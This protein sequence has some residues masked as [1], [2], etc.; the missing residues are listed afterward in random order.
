M[1]NFDTG[2][3]IFCGLGHGSI[4]RMRKTLLVGHRSHLPFCILTVKQELSVDHKQRYHCLTTLFDDSSNYS[5]YHKA[6]SAFEGM[7]TPYIPIVGV[8]LKL[9]IVPT[10]KPRSL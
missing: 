10:A 1:R 5:E 6:L 2:Y 3:M 8:C 7:Q 9:M 4:F